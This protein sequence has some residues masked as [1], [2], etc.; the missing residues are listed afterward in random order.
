VSPRPTRWVA[1]RH[2]QGRA[3]QAGSDGGHVQITAP[4]AVRVHFNSAS[5]NRSEQLHDAQPARRRCTALRSRKSSLMNSMYQGLNFAGG[6]VGV[7][8]RANTTVGALP[9]LAAAATSSIR[10]GCDRTGASHPNISMSASASFA[11]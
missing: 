10:R 1:D 11:H 8:A 6:E 5:S 2:Q 3:G 9:S 7:G 4:R